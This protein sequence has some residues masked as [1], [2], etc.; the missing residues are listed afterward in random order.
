MQILLQTAVLF[1][2]QKLTW[3]AGSCVNERRVSASSV[4]KFGRNRIGMESYI[5]KHTE[6]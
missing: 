3:I 6:A 4:Q 1:T 2:F 5:E